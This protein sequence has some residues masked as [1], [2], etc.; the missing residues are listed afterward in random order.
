ML[1]IIYF[2]KLTLA[3]LA[4]LHAQDAPAAVHFYDEY[5]GHYIIVL[6][7]GLIQV[8]W[9]FACDRRTG[10]GAGCVS[11]GLLGGYLSALLV[12]ESQSVPILLPIDVLLFWRPPADRCVCREGNIELVICLRS[13]ARRVF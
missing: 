8:Y 10:G 4:S 3:C 7:Y 1:Q 12:L 9:S 5:V 13:C 6:V 2:V 11:L